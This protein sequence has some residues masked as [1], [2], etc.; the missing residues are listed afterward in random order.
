M[1]YWQ[2][3]ATLMKSADY[4]MKSHG[5]TKSLSASHIDRQPPQICEE[6]LQNESEHW[7]NQQE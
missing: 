2:L 1:K 4:Q 6:N 7:E 5:R 3:D